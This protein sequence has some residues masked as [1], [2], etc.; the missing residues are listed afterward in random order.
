MTPRLACL[1]F[2]LSLVACNE[3]A[4]DDGDGTAN[5]PPGFSEEVCALDAGPFTTEID[6]RWFPLPVGQIAVFDGEDDGAE[7]HL[8]ISVI[9]ETEAVGGVTTRVVEE[10]E[11]EDGEVVEISRNFFAQAR[12]G[13]VCYFGEDVDIYEDGEV[14]N[15]D[16]AWRAG[17]GENE[18]G[19]IMPAEPVVGLSYAQ[20]I[21]PDIAEDH[22]DHIAEG[23]S[24]TVPAGTFTDTI[25]VEEWTPLEPGHTSEKIYAKD[26]GLV[27]DN[28]VELVSLTRP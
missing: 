11:E 28:T 12:D 1:A 2:A 10:H 15:H 8:V 7:I 18:P 25:R 14:A 16:G 5:P 27:V 17:D 20:E 23:E 21:A 26:T 4:D 22:A 3:S 13:T 19:I 6:N 24:V 9:D